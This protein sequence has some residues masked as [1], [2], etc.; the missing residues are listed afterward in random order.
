MSC[1]VVHMTLALPD[2]R[3]EKEGVAELARRLRGP[4]LPPPAQRRA[5]RLAAGATLRDIA[6]ALQVNAM[7]ISRW[8]RGITEPWPRHHATYLCLLVALA[9][10]AAELSA[11]S[12]RG[13]TFDA[14]QPQK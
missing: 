10:V 13:A 3:A 14:E 8:E 11:S 4:Q 5:I 2:L 12:A 9:D 7:T 1:S 6:E